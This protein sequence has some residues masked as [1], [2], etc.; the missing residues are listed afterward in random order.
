MSVR[1]KCLEQAWMSSLIEFHESSMSCAKSLEQFWEVNESLSM[2]NWFQQS[3][4]G[5]EWMMSEW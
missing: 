2:P 5:D 4:L 3:Q 1:P